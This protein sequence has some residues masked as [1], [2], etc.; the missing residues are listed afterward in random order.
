MQFK[1]ERISKEYNNLTYENPKLFYL[2]FYLDQFCW[3]EFEKR[4]TLTHI[5]RTVEEHN[6]LYKETPESKRPAT[7]PH[8]Y[9]KACDIRSSTF[10][11]PEIT[12]MLKFLNTWSYKSGQG[13]AVAIYH[14]IAGNVNHFHVQC[15]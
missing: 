1:S 14:A 5:F 15:D 7:S 3:L 13:K 2:L 9:W 12:R 6:E 4:I 11:G 8:M 10:S